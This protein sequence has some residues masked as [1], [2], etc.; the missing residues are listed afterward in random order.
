VRNETCPS[1]AEPI[2]TDRLCLRVPNPRDA[3]PLYGLFADAEVM[4]GLGKEPVSAVED[5]RGSIEEAIE[6]WKIDGL[7]MFVLETTAA[8]RRIV[9]QAGLMIFDTRGWTPSTH[10]NAGRHAQPE[11]GWALMQEHWG[12][13]YATEAAAAIR[14]WAWECREIDRLVS[15]IAPDNV[16]SQ[17]VARR[18]GAIPTQP[19]TPADSKR[20]AVIWKHRHGG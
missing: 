7:G 17:R 9:G 6:G 14:D 4:R 13:G 10:A 1:E 12:R 15:L 2:Y 20:Q 8:D 19:V 11:L 3:E 5:V 18:I 16:R